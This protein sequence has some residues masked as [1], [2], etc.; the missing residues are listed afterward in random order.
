MASLLNMLFLPSLEHVSIPNQATQ[1]Q[2]LSS[3][4]QDEQPRLSNTTSR[5]LPLIPEISPYNPSA[6]FEIP[7]VERD[8]T[9][10]METTN[11]PERLYTEPLYGR[12]LPPTT[13]SAKDFEA[14]STLQYQR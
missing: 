13:H 7:P 6:R 11:P 1:H 14:S 8:H 2:P 4:I 12:P 9:K 3:D 10:M 5:Q